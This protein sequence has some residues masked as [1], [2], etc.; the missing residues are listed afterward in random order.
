[1]G[2][3]IAT[4]TAK[5]GFK[6]ILIEKTQDLADAA[7]ENIHHE[8][9]KQIARWGMTESEKK[10][11]L[12]NLQVGDDLELAQ[13]SQLLIEAVP[14]NFK[15]KRDLFT[16]LNS[17][18]QPE[19]I[20]TTV[21][22][23]LSVTE[24]ATLLSYP[25]KMIGLHF[26]NPVLRIKLVEIVRGFRTSEE[27]YDTGRE[28]V[29]SLGKKGIEVFESPGF[30]TTRLIIPLLNEAMYAL[31]E[32]VASAE[33]IDMAMKLGYGL[34]MGPLELADRI[35]LDTLLNLM[36]HLFRETGDLK[37]RPCPLI[38]KLIRAQ[39]LGVK[40]GEGF[41]KYDLETGKKERHPS[42]ERL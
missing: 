36:R 5:S 39:N 32:G 19:T 16:Q 7:L 20:F 31:L 33:D 30:I 17:I 41:F 6:T 3:G 9:D 22:S 26:L 2:S 18:C 37:F 42:D 14:D 24:L 4:L 25:E 38:R 34:Q 15:L 40:T 27:T 1:M 10:L 11:V 21:S 12:A 13:E 35:G 28:F 8:M 23:V 29:N